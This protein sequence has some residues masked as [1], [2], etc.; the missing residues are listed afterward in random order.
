MQFAELIWRPPFF[1]ELATKV[2]DVQYFT[3][4]IY[5]F[6]HSKTDFYLKKFRPVSGLSS[7]G[8]KERIRYLVRNKDEK[9][10]QSTFSSVF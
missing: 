3:E 8:G 4:E 1:W 10:D 9:I 5:L 7:C 6:L 2:K